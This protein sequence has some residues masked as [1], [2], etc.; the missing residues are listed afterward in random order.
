MSND[1]LILGSL[2]AI[3]VLLVLIRTHVPLMI[4]ATCAGFLLSTLWGPEV[5]ALLSE[6][7]DLGTDVFVRSVISIGLFI[8]PPLLI[9]FHFRGTQSSRWIQ[10]IVPAIFWSA[11]AFAMIV[12][13]LPSEVSNELEST[14]ILAAFSQQ[15]LNLLVL[16]SIIVAVVEFMSQHGALMPRG[17][18]R[19]PKS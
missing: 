2:G 12:R 10:Q 8:L 16:S 4:L 7:T 14:S 13:L 6:H 15:F 19:P 11:F 17:R 18:G 3:F 1:L 9:G 5:F